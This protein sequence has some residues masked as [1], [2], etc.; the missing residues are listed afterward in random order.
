[1]GCRYGKGIGI[2]Q[3]YVQ[4]ARYYLLAG[5]E[6]KD[7]DSIAQNNL[8]LLYEEGQGVPKDQTKA[9]S[10]F[11]FSADQGNLYGHY[12]LARMRETGAGAPKDLGHALE[13]YYWA[14]KRGHQL[15]LE[16]LDELSPERANKA[17]RKLRLGQ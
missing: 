16:K 1:V 17:R 2:E 8:G 15:S 11:A 10:L 12:N 4:A 6:K 7:G 5:G 9:I 14:A 13:L 3:N